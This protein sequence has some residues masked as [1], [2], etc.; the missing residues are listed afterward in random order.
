[1]DVPDT[2]ICPMRQAYRRIGRALEGNTMWANEDD[3]WTVWIDDEDI[4]ALLR[5][6]LPE[7]W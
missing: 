6:E 2:A 3:T 5:G 7:G 4:K 1:M